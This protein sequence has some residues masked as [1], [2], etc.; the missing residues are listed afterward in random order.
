MKHLLT[1]K[2]KKSLCQIET[3]KKNEN[4]R[5]CCLSNGNSNELL[6]FLKEESAKQARQ[7][8][9]F[10]N[11]MMAVVNNNQMQQGPSIP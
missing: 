8:E 4:Q 7:D 6:K 1:R 5:K 10:L 2:S 11:L 9:I 3:R